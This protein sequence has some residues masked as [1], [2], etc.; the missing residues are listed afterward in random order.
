ME[1]LSYNGVEYEIRKLFTQTGEVRTGYTIWVWPDKSS[2]EPH[3][4]AGVGTIQGSNGL[5]TYGTYEEAKTA[6]ESYLGKN[7]RF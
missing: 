2:E 5:A 7:L 1:R 3:P 4:V 6:A